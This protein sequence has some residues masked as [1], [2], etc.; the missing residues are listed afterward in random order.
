MNYGIN[1]V[2][3]FAH[4]KHSQGLSI[5]TTF[6]I[7][8]LT[9]RP[10]CGPIH[11][12]LPTKQPLQ[13]PIRHRQSTLDFKSVPESSMTPDLQTEIS[14][15]SSIRRTSPSIIRVIRTKTAKS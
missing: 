4:P 9:E 7:M 12:L 8:S 2:I 11:W 6:T 14:R 10:A 5:P 15:A 1:Q 3:Q 13:L